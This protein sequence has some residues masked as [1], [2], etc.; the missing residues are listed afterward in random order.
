MIAR[1]KKEEEERILAEAEAEQIRK[2]LEEEAKKMEEERRK[3]E[4][5]ERQR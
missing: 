1:E 3:L 2:E 4:D 5:L